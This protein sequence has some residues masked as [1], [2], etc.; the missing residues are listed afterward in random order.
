MV[1]SSPKTP[2]KSRGDAAADFVTPRSPGPPMPASLAIK[3][4]AMR[5]AKE[6]RAA[7]RRESSA[8]AQGVRSA[9]RAFR[10]S[11]AKWTALRPAATKGSSVTEID[12]ALAL[13][14]WFLYDE[15]GNLIVPR[16]ARH[17]GAREAAA[18]ILSGRSRKVVMKVMEHLSATGEL[19]ETDTSKRGR[20]SLEYH[21]DDRITDVMKAAIYEYV[22]EA[23]SAETATYVSRLS[24]QLLLTDRFGVRASLARVGRVLRSMNIE[25][26]KV[27]GAHNRTN[28]PVYKLWSKV[29]V[30]Q[31]HYAIAHDHELLFVDE[32][33]AHE[34]GALNRTW[35]FADSDEVSWLRKG[36]N[37]RRVCFINAIHRT[38]FL[39]N[40]DDAG[41][42][43]SP[44][45]GNIDG[46]WPTTEMLFHAGKGG[47]KGDYHG[48]FD[49]AIFSKWVHNRLIPALKQRFSDK[50]VCVVMDN[51]PYHCA[52]RDTGASGAYRFNPKGCTKAALFDGLRRVGCKFLDVK[53][54]CATPDH[55]K[56][57]I[58]IRVPIN[59]VEVVK[60]ASKGVVP[61]MEEFREAATQ[62]IMD[63]KPDALRND[64]EHALHAAS[65][66]KW[67]VCWSVPYYPDGTIIEKA[68]AM[69]KGYAAAAWYR[70]RKLSELCLDLQQGMY[71]LHKPRVG[72]LNYRGGGF[73]P[74]RE[75]GQCKPAEDLLTWLFH[76]DGEGMDRLIK[77]SGGLSGTI[78]DLRYDETDMEHATRYRYNALLRAWLKRRVI[79]ENE[80]GK[81]AADDASAE[82]DSESE[83]EIDE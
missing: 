48:N 44:P 10:K 5:A 69:V 50:H 78:E 57:E 4:A 33:Y 45:V 23:R 6:A 53:S 18:G 20:A 72:V 66:G 27:K 83:N 40:H 21:D 35:T 1:R 24:V 60:K 49:A 56:A 8:T 75:T 38:G 36:G 64:V 9:N 43:L 61:T 14:G 82:D 65:G 31:M 67:Y 3:M 76:K 47:S 81:E 54:D 15:D 16:F 32:S 62:W 30:L 59:N 68:W 26:K 12:A 2:S 77:F 37:G 74:D 42:Y 73:A 17:D 71:T 11:L 13:A 29:F 51:A 41:N 22:D 7:K 80:A 46:V 52:T 58:T 63:N 25:Y 39:V 70:G 55:P 34:N 28:N 19:Y 79:A